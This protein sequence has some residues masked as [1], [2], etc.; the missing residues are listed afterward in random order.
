VLRDEVAPAATGPAAEAL[1]PSDDSRP[2]NF[3]SGMEFEDLSG[4]KVPEPP[5]PAP[6]PK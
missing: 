6:A 3:F 4:K 2:G 1:S 5:A